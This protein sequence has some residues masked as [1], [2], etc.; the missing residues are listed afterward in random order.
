MKYCLGLSFGFKKYH[1]PARL[2]IFADD[3]LVDD[4]TLDEDIPTR[5][6]NLGDAHEHEVR[7]YGV[8]RAPKLSVDGYANRYK[9]KSWNQTRC[10]FVPTKSFVY[11]LDD[12]C[13]TKH[14]VIECN[15][16]NSNYTNGFMTNWS[17]LQ[18]HH[19]FLC[20]V[21]LLDTEK[22]RQRLSKNIRMDDIVC[23]WPMIGS[24]CSLTANLKPGH[25]SSET[26][27]WQELYGTRLGGSFKLTIPLWRKC[28]YVFTNKDHS[29]D[30]DIDPNMFDLIEVLDL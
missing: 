30:T 29:V 13:L 16:P 28:G 5:C 26:V 7:K 3:Q 6:I 18:F 23:W 21:D 22:Y 10:L 25:S 11:K 1:R 19:M 27:P 17:E 2:R 4:V 14:I 15:N 8:E 12:A 24:V 20:P 9:T